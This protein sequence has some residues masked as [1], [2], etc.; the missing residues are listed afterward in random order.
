MRKLRQRFIVINTFC[1]SDHFEQDDPGRVQIK[2]SSSDL[3]AVEI[4][5]SQS[6]IGSGRS[7]SHMVSKKFWTATLVF[8]FTF[9]LLCL[10]LNLSTYLEMR[11]AI[12]KNVQLGDQVND[13]L[14]E[15]V[16]LQEEIHALRSD[17]ARVAREVERLGLN[18]FR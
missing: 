4:T 1:C 17:R 9:S 7:Y 11:S 2:I 3:S 18:K 5:T 15:T 6:I 14:D 8:G 13:L 16:A 12:D 10:S